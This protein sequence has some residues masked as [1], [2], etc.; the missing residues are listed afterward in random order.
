MIYPAEGTVISPRPALILKSSKNV[1]NAKAFIDYLLSDQAQKMVAAA[2]L[3][4]GRS[5]VKV[6]GRPDAGEIPTLKV[7]SAWMIKNQK[8]VIQK[9]A[10]IFQKQII[11]IND[12]TVR[13]KKMINLNFKR[14]GMLLA[15]LI[16]V[17][18]IVIPLP[19]LYKNI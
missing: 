17:M 13:I 1:A 16:L 10:N 8:S 11:S 12:S 19:K 15:C 18:L 7:N 2:Y 5:D 6:E 3:L 14:L 4:P 9:L